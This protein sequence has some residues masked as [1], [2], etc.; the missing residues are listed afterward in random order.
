MPIIN[1]IKNPIL[2]SAAEWLAMIGLAVL[3]FFVMRGFLFRTAHVDGSSMA[4]TLEHG[5][6][7]FLNRLVYHLSSPKAGDI[8]AFPYAENPDDVFIKRIIAVPGDVVDFR[9]GF[10]IING[11]PLDDDFSGEPT[12]SFGDVIFP[13][14]VE[15]GHFF[16]LGDNRN[17]SQDSRFSGVGNVPARDIIGRAEVRVFP[18]KRAG[19]VR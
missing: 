16:V 2:R 9:D 15:D 18:L 13:I 17:G 4:P 3:L 10:F 11:A 6:F 14:T 5:D 7:I 8:I 19:W 1:R 12:F